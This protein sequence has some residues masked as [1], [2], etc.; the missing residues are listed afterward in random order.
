[1]QRAR[2][3]VALML[4]WVVATAA[5][6]QPA[7][8]PR[9]RAEF[10]AAELSATA[11]RVVERFMTEKRVPGLVLAVIRNGQ[12]VVERGYGVRS[13]GDQ[14]R[15][16][17][18]T[19]F[20]IGS[21]SKAITAIGIELLAERGKLTLDDPAGRYVH[22]LPPAW[23][24][25]PLKYFLAHQSG[26]PEIATAREPTF[27]QQVH[28][29]EHLPM[30]FKPGMKQQYNNF[31]F[32]IAGKVIEGAS[33][34]PYLEFM[35]DEVFRPL[36]M[37]RTGYG[38]R[39]ANASPGHYLRKN[40]HYEVVEE[41]IPKGGEYGIPS[42]F[43]Q[44][45]LADLVRLYHAIQ[46][47]KLLTPARTREMVSPVT[48]GKTGTPG[49]FAREA[50]GVTI[51]AKNGAAAGYASQF[52]FVPSRGMGVIFVMNLQAQGLNTDALANALLREI[53]GLPLPERAGVA[54]E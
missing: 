3:G 14:V 11:D 27:E 7:P 50:G 41:A 46:Q 24:S 28:A 18:E 10:D 37:T 33:G 54:A 15:P 31:N 53:C 6:A 17:A 16:D 25:I 42:G 19:L 13:P 8:R 30:S 22:V 48:P 34:K 21:L 35:R 9:A 45:T 38:Q 39:D 36:G 4:L 32:A 52:Q 44:T 29:V 49:W 40:G 5:E 26:I 23:K 47:H 20:Y 43:L 2:P 51:V 1:M 12:L